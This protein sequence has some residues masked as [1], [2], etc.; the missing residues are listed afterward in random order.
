MLPGVLLSSIAHAV[1]LWGVS[2]VSLYVNG[3]GLDRHGVF[4]PESKDVVV[5]AFSF[6]FHHFG[7][8]LHNSRCQG[9][10]IMRADLELF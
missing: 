8:M 2:F 3:D 9:E 6:F 10:K 5:P 1:N 7:S 4:A